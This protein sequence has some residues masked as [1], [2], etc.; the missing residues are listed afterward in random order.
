MSKAK[1]ANNILGHIKGTFNLGTEASSVVYIGT[2]KKQKHTNF[3]YSYIFSFIS[4]S[5]KEVEQCFECY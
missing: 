4:I 3:K 5:A 1:K 2:L